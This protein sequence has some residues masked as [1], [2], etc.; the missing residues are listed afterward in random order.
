MIKSYSKINLFLKVLKKNNN[1]L[2]NIQSSVMLLN[3]YDQII[4]KNT[5]KNQDEIKLIGKFKKKINSKNN[6]I[7]KSLYILRKHNFLDKKN[8]YKIT[9]NKK[10]PVFA[11]LGGGTSNAAFLVKYFLK[12]K[13]NEKILKI[14]EKEIGSDFRLFFYKH[15][16]QK[17]LKKIIKFKKQLTLFFVLVYPH[18]NC[19]TKQ[20]YSKVTK[21]NLPLK[22][23]LS[24]YNSKNTYIKFIQNE[25]NDL[26][27]IV[28]KKFLKIK[29]TLDL[30][31][32]QKKCLFSRMTGS[33]SVCFGVFADKK[34]AKNAYRIIAKKLP[35]YWC[36]FAKSI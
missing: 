33:G 3:L 25:K 13:I 2:H 7:T 21:F 23:N 27:K 18:I 22:N 1:G 8:K 26:Q 35:N 28:E 29:K 5:N 30:I 20:I 11:G 6:S 12:N 9:I 31:K 36:I 24:K 34:S 10:I 32:L 4:I 15:S 16:F 17:S 14:F 19:S